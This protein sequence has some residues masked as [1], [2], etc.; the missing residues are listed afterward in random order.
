MR[1]FTRGR[2]VVK[3]GQNSV[4]VV[5]EWPLTFL[6]EMQQVLVVPLSKGTDRFQFTKYVWISEKLI[7]QIQYA[8]TFWKRSQGKLRGS[9]W[10]SMQILFLHEIDGQ[11]GVSILW[12]HTGQLEFGM[13]T[14]ALQLSVHHACT[15]RMWE[16][17][18]KPAL[19]SACYLESV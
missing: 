7:L 14:A 12:V 10:S 2:W 16:T 11:S 4:Y 15:S 3:K 8:T 17:L 6:N 19:Q 9:I 5:I 13:K 18:K 1:L